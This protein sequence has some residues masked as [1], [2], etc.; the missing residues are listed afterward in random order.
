MIE[1]LQW[2]N[3]PRR[4]TIPMN[5]TNNGLCHQNYHHHPPLFIFL[6]VK[7]KH[8]AIDSRNREIFHHNYQADPMSSVLCMLKANP[9]VEK[10]EPM[11][12][13]NKRIFHHNHHYPPQSI[14]QRLK[15]II[16][17]QRIL[18]HNYHHSSLLS[19]FCTGCSILI[20]LHGSYF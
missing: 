5:S 3:G 15:G 2:M 8:E 16:K 13:R 6:R 4:M 12:L 11:D 19:T 14:L 7:L 17:G 10:H 18:H 20:K 9:Q 1:I